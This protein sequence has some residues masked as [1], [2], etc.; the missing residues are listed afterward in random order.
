MGVA[1]N[2]QIRTSEGRP[3]VPLPTQARFHGSPATFRSL[4]GGFGSGKSMAGAV[5]ALLQSLEAPL[6]AQGG[7]G[8]VARYEYRE[9]RESSWKILTDI[10]PNALIKDHLKSQPKLILKNNFEIIGWNLKD[11]Q[12]LASLNLS[13]FWLDEANED[14]IDVR[15]YNQLC[16]R[17][18]NPLGNR[19]G[20]LTGNPAGKNWLWERFFAWQE[21]GRQYP[22]H[23]GFQMTT[24][25]NVYLPPGYE[26][27]LR[28]IYPAEWIE[29]YLQGSFSVFE[30]MILSEWRPGLHLIAPF[31]IPDEWPRY[32]GLDHG[33]VNPTAGVWLA[34]DF[35]GNHII[36]REHYVRN[37]IPAENAQQILQ[38]EHGE[39]V[40]WRVI[41]PS[42]RALESA[43]GTM[44]RIIDQYRL[45]GLLCDPG[46]N[47]VRDSIALLKRLLQPDP[48]HKFPAWHPRAGEMGAPWV[49]V[50]EDL[51][52]LR[53]EIEQWKWKDVKPGAGDKEKPV[54]KNDH[55]I[56]AWR[57][58]E[59]R[60]PHKAVETLQPTLRDRFR[61]IEDELFGQVPPNREAST[62][63]VNGNQWVK[64]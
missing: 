44:E 50:F 35:E 21:G 23:E 39:N 22:D 62:L 18:R 4:V 56:A 16:G 12:N 42:T 6:N 37:A 19:Q 57:Y 46:N 2:L 25:E 10:I 11:H 64:R 40:H 3:Y 33:L 53:W 54:T 1:V 15:V 20:W 49:F 51:K 61:W 55:L 30:G 48:Q 13:W 9:L 5:E 41:D 58:L 34:T 45:A 32:F 59:M 31:R 47:N 36:Y 17:L 8:L 27:R 14:G 29:L 26:D 7:Q 63:D 60:S 38:A 28:E 24:R 52:A 43:G